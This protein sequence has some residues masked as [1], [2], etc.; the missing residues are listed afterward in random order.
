MDRSASL[1]L[2]SVGGRYIGANMLYKAARSVPVE[3]RGEFGVAV[4]AAINQRQQ[5]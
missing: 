2:V 4:L 5:A 1:S 3:L